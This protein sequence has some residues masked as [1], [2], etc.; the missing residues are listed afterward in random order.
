MFFAQPQIAME[1]TELFCESTS[2]TFRRGKDPDA[3]G[4]WRTEDAFFRYDGGMMAKLSGYYIY[5]EKKFSD[6]DVYD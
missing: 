1:I 2:Q 5:Y 4:S 6:A 3:D